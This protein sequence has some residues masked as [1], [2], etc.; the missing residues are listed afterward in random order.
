LLIE[1]GVLLSVSMVILITVF[2]LIFFANIRIIS[3]N[4]NIYYKI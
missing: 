1:I 2:I 3:A 4:N